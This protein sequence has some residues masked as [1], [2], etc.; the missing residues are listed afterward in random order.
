MNLNEI[1]VSSAPGA[2]PLDGINYQG[3]IEA[4]SKEEMSE[5]LKAFKARKEK[6][7]DRSKNATDSEFWFCA[8]FGSRAEKEQFLKAVGL[9]EQGDKY[10]DGHKL[11]EAVGVEIDR[12][13]FK[14]SAKPRPPKF[15]DEVGII[16]EEGGEKI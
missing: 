2:S 1:D 5:T 9:L 6:E 11:A 12:T 13:D 10:V 4:D 14:P 7:A 15:T 16:G 3:D 8:C